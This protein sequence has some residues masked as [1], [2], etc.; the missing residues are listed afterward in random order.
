MIPSDL[1]YIV[2]LTFVAVAL[3]Y[4]MGLT[5]L[6]L[7]VELLSANPESMIEALELGF[8]ELPKAMLFGL[9]FMVAFVVD[10][11]ITE[12]HKAKDRLERS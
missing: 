10:E 2:G 4:W 5:F 6:R 1:P 12:F 8:R 11:F 9:V 3:F 7:W